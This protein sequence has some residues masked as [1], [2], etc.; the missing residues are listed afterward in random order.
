MTLANVWKKTNLAA[1]R[2]SANVLTLCFMWLR[3]REEESAC[4]ASAKS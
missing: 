1:N 2:A 3:N 4:L